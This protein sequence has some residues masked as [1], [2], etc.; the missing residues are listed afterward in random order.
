V[1]RALIVERVN[2]RGRRS[3]RSLLAHA[4]ESARDVHRIQ[5]NFVV[6][7]EDEARWG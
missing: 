5:P 4:A 2:G 6:Q 7:P 1:L 3:R